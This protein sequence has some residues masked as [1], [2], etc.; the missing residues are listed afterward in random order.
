MRPLKSHF[1][2]QALPTL[3]LRFKNNE[4]VARDVI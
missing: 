4:Q 3:V 1:P 2:D